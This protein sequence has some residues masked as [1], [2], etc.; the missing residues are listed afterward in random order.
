MKTEELGI[1]RSNKSAGGPLDG[2]EK[3]GHVAEGR[4]QG[5]K[6]KPRGP[7]SVLSDQTN[8]SAVKQDPGLP[9]FGVHLGEHSSNPGVERRKGK[10][11][12]CLGHGGNGGRAQLYRGYVCTVA[13][14]ERRR[15]Q[16]WGKV[17]KCMSPLPRVN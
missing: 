14:V 12:G 17:E 5:R 1:A 7:I 2:D 10:S 8:K 4:L 9:G 11:A 13:E 6:T 3:M 15:E 16:K